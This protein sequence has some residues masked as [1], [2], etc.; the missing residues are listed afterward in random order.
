MEVIGDYDK[1]FLWSV[2]VKVW[3]LW[4]EEWIRERW[5][6]GNFVYVEIFSYESY[7]GV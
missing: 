7:R 3:L 4:F 5:G 6:G 2:G 1:Y